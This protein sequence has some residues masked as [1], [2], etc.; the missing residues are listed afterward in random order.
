MV[1]VFDANGDIIDLPEPPKSKMGSLKKGTPKL[2]S[3]NVGPSGISASGVFDNGEEDK[4]SVGVAVAKDAAVRANKLKELSKVVDFFESKISEVPVER[5]LEGR[6]QGLGQKFL[7]ALQANPLNPEDT[8]PSKIAAYESNL[9]GMKALIARG[10]GDVGNLSDVEQRNA[11]K[12]LP[13]I[14]DNAET[15]AQKIENFRTLMKMKGLSFDKNIKIKQN[16]PRKIS[17][18]KE[19]NV[20]GTKFIITGE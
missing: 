15:R 6:V 2:K 16:E 8:L 5:G 10:L 19:I 18:P 3:F 7:G 17:K 9:E 12:L 11:V 1:Q 13:N 4:R 14:T 20:G